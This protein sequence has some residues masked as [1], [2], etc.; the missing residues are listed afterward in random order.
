MLLDAIAGLRFLLQ[1]RPI[2]TWAILKSHFS[3][4]CNLNKIRKKRL[5]NNNNNYYDA[6][7][8]VW[9]YFV[10]NIRKANKL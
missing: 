5:P 8:I 2:H 6:V 10:L 1:G 9:S 3:F 4:Y 7:S